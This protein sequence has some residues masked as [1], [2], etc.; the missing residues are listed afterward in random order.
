MVHRLKW[1][2]RRAECSRP[3]EGA[4]SKEA[5][6]A[7]R[8]AARRGE[9]RPCEEAGGYDAQARSQGE[10]ARRSLCGG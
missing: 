4:A 9:E 1:S 7:M 10:A 2:R 6:E 8:V 3:E 5:K